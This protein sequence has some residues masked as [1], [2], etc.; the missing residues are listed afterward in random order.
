MMYSLYYRVQQ[1]NLLINLLKDSLPTAT[2]IF[3]QRAAEGIKPWRLEYGL[4]ES[5]EITD[6]ESLD[7]PSWHQTS[8]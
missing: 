6:F 7:L 8:L 2:I 3:D 1:E 5:L 4:V